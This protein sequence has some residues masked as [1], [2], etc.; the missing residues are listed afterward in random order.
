MFKKI[1]K[2]ILHC[3]RGVR[4]Q[5][6]CLEN[7]FLVLCIPC[8]SIRITR[9]KL[10]HT[11]DNTEDKMHSIYDHKISTELKEIFS[12][13]NSKNI[14]TTNRSCPKYPSKY[15]RAIQVS[16]SILLGAVILQT[17]VNCV[18]CSA[19]SLF[20]DELML[21]IMEI[22]IAPQLELFFTFSENLIGTTCR[23]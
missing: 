23:T 2:Y 14:E 4:T 5:M 13:I 10:I 11:V 9:Q 19:I 16:G 21:W 7:I 1:L 22:R 8:S 18:H 20:I 6:I 3:F 17:S 12:E 15:W